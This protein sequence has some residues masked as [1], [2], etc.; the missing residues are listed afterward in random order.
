MIWGGNVEEKSNSQITSSCQ[1]TATQMAGDWRERG[2]RGS[3][4]VV[5]PIRT[6]LVVMSQW[7]PSHCNIHIPEAAPA[8]PL[9]M[10]AQPAK[11]GEAGGRC[12]CLVWKT[13]LLFGSSI[14]GAHVAWAHGWPEHPRIGWYHASVEIFVNFFGFG[15]TVGTGNTGVE[16]QCFSLAKQL[17]YPFSNTSCQSSINL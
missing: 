9:A 13:S 10:V 2:H 8:W 12:H 15:G 5:W 14:Y 7:D 4:Y 3:A 16:T 11:H 17:L 1:E 6:D